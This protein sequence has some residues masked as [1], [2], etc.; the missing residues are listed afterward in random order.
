VAAAMFDGDD[1]A[2]AVGV[3]LFYGICEAVFLAIYCTIC[4]KVGWTKAPADENICTVIFTSYEV[5]EAMESD[6]E[7]IEIV[8]GGLPNG[9]MD[10][11]FSR[12]KEGYQIDEVSLESLH[13]PV[14]GD[15]TIEDLE[16][17]GQQRK[18]EVD[19]GLQPD[20]E[21][22]KGIRTRHANESLS[23][24]LPASVSEQ[25]QRSPLFQNPTADFLSSNLSQ[26]Q[27]T[28]VPNTTPAIKNVPATG[29]H[30]D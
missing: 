24:V 29:K 19:F 5:K 20:L 25:S 2:I 21:F 6:Q 8:L 14:E 15:F 17:E 30:I 4:W 27:G 7:S 12:T 22:S 13:N 28:H 3:P 9:P 18:V 11:I 16:E 26:T 10:L 23:P 1:L